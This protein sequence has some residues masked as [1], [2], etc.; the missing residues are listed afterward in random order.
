MTTWESREKSAGKA[1]R[2]RALDPMERISEVLFGLIMVLSFTGSLS[3]AESGQE[4][5]RT[6]LIGALGCNFAWGIIDAYFYVM[7]SL[8]QRGHGIL[9]LRR[10]RETADPAEANSLIADALP[11]VLVSVLRPGDLETLRERLA[12]LPEPPKRIPFYRDD[13]RGALGVFLFVFLSTFP[14]TIPFVL[15]SDPVRALRV[16]NAIAIVLLF[17]GGYK[18]AKYSGGHPWRFGFV[19]VGIG[20]ALVALTIALGG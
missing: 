16:S 5:V 3:V 10:L 12:T 1:G 11:P 4:Q 6:M 15:M 9:V 8:G 14:V 20:A 2:R 17:L 13:F 7:N 18:L 19:M